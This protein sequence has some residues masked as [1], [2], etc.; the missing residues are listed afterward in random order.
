MY[1]AFSHTFL[2]LVVSLTAEV[3]IITLILG[4]LLLR[5]REIDSINVVSS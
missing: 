3:D 2:H 5:L 1:Q 4:K